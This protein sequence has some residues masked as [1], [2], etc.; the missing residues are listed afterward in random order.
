MTQNCDKIFREKI[1][2]FGVGAEKIGNRRKVMFT[3][4]IGRERCG[5]CC[6]EENRKGAIKFIMVYFILMIDITLQ[7]KTTGK[8]V[9]S[10]SF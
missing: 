2:Y 4:T 6:P 8:F 5:R 9:C 3:K 10:V 1:T 7:N